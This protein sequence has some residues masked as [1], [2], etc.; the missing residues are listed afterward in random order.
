MLFDAGKTAVH[1]AHDAEQAVE[2]LRVLAKR[3]GVLGPVP[4]SLPL[5]CA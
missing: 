4:A 1:R 3:G 2:D 5:A